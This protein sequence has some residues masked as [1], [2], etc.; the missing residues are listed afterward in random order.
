MKMMENIVILK[1]LIFFIFFFLNFLI[2]KKKKV[3]STEGFYLIIILKFF[4]IFF[5]LGQ[6]DNFYCN[7]NKFTNS[8]S[9]FHAHTNISKAGL[10]ILTKTGSGYYSKNGIL[11]VLKKKLN[12]K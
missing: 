1:M 11:M 10:N 9:D 3:V 2:I 5:F 4:Y 8:K 6:F 12:K 7:K